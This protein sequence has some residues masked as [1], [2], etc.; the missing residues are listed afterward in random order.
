MRRG[1]EECTPVFHTHYIYYCLETSLE[2]EPSSEKL[3]SAI[4]LT[5][6]ILTA[7][8]GVAGFSFHLSFELI[9]PPYKHVY[10]MTNVTSALSSSFCFSVTTMSYSASWKYLLGPVW[11]GIPSGMWIWGSS[12][13]FLLFSPSTYCQQWF[14]FSFWLDCRIWYF[15]FFRWLFYILSISLIS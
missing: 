10:L 11:S 13:A 1:K 12:I 5:F 6:F 8:F 4:F 2:R 3:A 14:L 9:N 7:C 15:F